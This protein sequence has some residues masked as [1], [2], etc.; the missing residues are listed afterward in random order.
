ML[1]ELLFDKEKESNWTD[2]ES[3]LYLIQRSH[4][5]ASSSFNKI[6]L[7]KVYLTM[8]VTPPLCSFLR[9]AVTKT[10]YR[11]HKAKTLRKNYEK[12][13]CFTLYPALADVSINIT[14]SSFALRWPSSVD[15]CL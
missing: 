4:I 7:T 8:S 10:P 1:C 11:L 6:H 15:T 3:H 2:A 13:T 14:L 12:C 5:I 9:S